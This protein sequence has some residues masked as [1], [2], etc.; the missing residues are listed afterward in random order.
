MRQSASMPIT[1]N[2]RASPID[3]SRQATGMSALLLRLDQP[4]VTHL[5]DVITRQDENESQRR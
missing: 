4:T 2:A 3:V 5:V 1:P